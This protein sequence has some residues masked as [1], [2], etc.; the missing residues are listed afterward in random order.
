MNPDKKN[1][2]KY[3]KKYATDLAQGISGKLE[4]A[5]MFAGYIIKT[6]Y[7]YSRPGLKKRQACFQVFV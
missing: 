5:A 4:S 6:E 1:V 2:S 7:F 3:A